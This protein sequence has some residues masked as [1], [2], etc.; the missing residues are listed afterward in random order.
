MR[1]R[2]TGISLSFLLLMLGTQAIAQTLSCGATVVGSVTLQANLNCPTGH[3]LAVGSG[4][5]LNCAG[6][7]ITGGEQPGQYGIYVREVSNATVQNCTVESFEVG[8]RLRGATNATVRDS[9]TQLNTRYG[10]EITL[11][12]TGA[13][14]LSNSVL[15]NGDE[16]IH[17]SGPPDRDALHQIEANLV[18]GNGLEGIYLLDSDANTIAENLVRDHG[19]AGLYIK[20]SHQNTITGNTLTND[21]IQLVNGSQGNTF[22]GNTIYGQRMKFDGAP[23]NTVDTMSVQGQSGQPSVAYEFTNAASGNT[24]IGSEALNP[25]DYHIRAANQSK[26]IVFTRFS[27]VPT[28]KCSVDGTSSVKVTDPN[29]NPLKCGR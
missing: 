22:R 8:I 9:T 11:N 14:I 27:A 7:T 17:V 18:D 6:K 1:T 24:I 29:G 5:T 25:V 4:A 2:L 10:L 28:L 26:N 19:T 3:G 12:S 13:L 16:G 23:N 15:D 21:P 20:G